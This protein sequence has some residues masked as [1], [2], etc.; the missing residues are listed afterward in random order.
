MSALEP[1]NAA[2]RVRVGSRNAAKLEAVRLGLGGFLPGLEIEGADVDSGVDPQPLG[3]DEIA[4][5]ARNRA[6]AAWDAGNCGLACGIEDGL[7]AVPVV[8]TGWLNVGAAALFDG[9]D[10]SLGFT[11]GFEYP[12]DCV[13]AATSAPRTPIGDAFDAR[14]E[15]PDGWPA[16]QPGG[17]NVGAL[18][19]NRLTRAQYG[20]Q[21]VICAYLRLLHPTLYA[22]E[23]RP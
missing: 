7:I 10:Y 15:P 23:P 1:G 13:A 6:R 2:T 9:K 20:A 14:F 18:T 22:Q 21:A 5:G 19:A 3:F 17:G 16:P 4:R 11:A 8:P 12:P